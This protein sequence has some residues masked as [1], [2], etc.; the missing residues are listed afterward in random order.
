MRWNYTAGRVERA[1]LDDVADGQPLDWQWDRLSMARMR[2]DIAE[3]VVTE[4]NGRIVPWLCPSRG[5][6]EDLLLSVAERY[7]EAGEGSPIYEAVREYVRSL[8]HPA[9]ATLGE[10]LKGAD[11]LQRHETVATTTKA[12]YRD[13]REAAEA[14]GGVER[15]V[16]VIGR[17]PYRRWCFGPQPTSAVSPDMVSRTSTI[18]T[19]A[20]RLVQS[21]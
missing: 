21:K 3:R 20:D 2:E 1:C 13:A 7:R 9:R 19:P 12:A 4:R 11:A 17:G 15:Q 8:R 6:E 18:V 16:Q 14:E 10:L 5:R